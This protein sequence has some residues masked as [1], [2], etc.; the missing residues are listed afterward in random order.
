MPSLSISVPGKTILFGEHAVVYGFP[1]IA[2]PLNS[3]SLNIKV[4]AR[5]NEKGT[6]IINKKMGTRFLLKDLS[7]DHTYR[8]SILLIL[9]ALNIDRLPALQI[10][11]SS[12]IPISSGLGS[13][14]AFAVCLVRALSGFLGFKLTDM[15]V[16]E[17]AF[18]I[19]T[20][21]HGTPSGIDNTVVTF[22]KLVYFIKGFS[23]TFLKVKE[24]FTL[25]VADT[26]IR[27]VT[28]DTVAEVKIK[29]AAN[30]SAVNKIIEE[31][32]ALA[33]RAKRTLE[34]SN[35]VTLGVLMSENH[36]L[37]QQLGVSGEELDHLVVTAVK[38]GA[39]GAKLCG[40]G[41][42]GNIVALVDEM[43]ADFIKSALL[44]NGSTNCF[45]SRIEPDK[46]EI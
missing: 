12:S 36:A 4:S 21:L 25:V 39:F 2:I 14:A 24:P 11:I 23:P 8:K 10:I 35:L 22:N 44:D 19:E 28:K 41:K 31:I 5:P 3:I 46:K 34:E 9:N 1:A 16:N 15:K 26:G 20:I 38:N 29:K 30:P 7:P 27:S 32:G 17:I 37:L 40:S 13:S 45:I 18:E 33:I 6:L 42:G 43:N